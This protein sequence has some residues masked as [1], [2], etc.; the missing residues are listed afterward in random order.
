MTRDQK[1]RKMGFRKVPQRGGHTPIWAAD[2]NVVRVAIWPTDLE[3]FVDI[4][5]TDSTNR[6]RDESLLGAY[7]A[8][9]TRAVK[10]LWRAYSD[11]EPLEQTVPYLRAEMHFRRNR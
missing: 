11:G 7:R 2:D 1:L 4:E 6:A 9:F 10:A 8:P 3:G 5:V